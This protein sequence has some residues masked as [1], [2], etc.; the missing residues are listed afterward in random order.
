MI[1]LVDLPELSKV[2]TVEDSALRRRQR[3]LTE[4][5]AIYSLSFSVIFLIL[6]DLFVVFKPVDVFVYF[7]HQVGSDKEK[8]CEKK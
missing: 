6:G 8:E 3:F 7:N 4:T 5:S 1:C 2:I